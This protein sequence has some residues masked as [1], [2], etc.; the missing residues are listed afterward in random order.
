V[1]THYCRKSVTC[2]GDRG[3]PDLF[4]CGPVGVGW[5]EIK[6]PGDRL[7]PEQTAWRYALLAVGQVYEV[8]YENDLGSGH[9]IDLFLDFLSTPV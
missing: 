5:I 6:T 2:T 1:R 7:K 4:L 8:M 9:A 3:L